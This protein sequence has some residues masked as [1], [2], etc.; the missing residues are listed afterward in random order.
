MQTFNFSNVNYDEATEFIKEN[1]YLI[2]DNLFTKE[3]CDNYVSRTINA[4]QTINPELNH[5]E[6]NKWTNI[7]LPPQT[8]TGMYQSLIC[9]INPVK[10]I[11]ENQN[12]KKIFSEIYSRIKTNYNVEDELVSS[13]DGINFKPNVRG[14]YTN[15]N[16]KDWAHLDQTKRNDIYKC[17]QGQVVFTNTS[18]SFVCSPKSHKLHDKILNICG[19]KEKDSSNWCKIPNEKYSKCKELVE[20]IGGHWQ[21]PIKVKA[22]TCILWFSTTIHSAKHSEKKETFTETDPY[23]GY[24]CV[25]YI[26]YRPKNEFTQKQIEKIQTNLENNRNMNHWNT[27]TFPIC[28]NSGYFP[29]TNYHENIQVLINNPKKMYELNI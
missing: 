18:A 21:I 1:G 17:L 5:R 16:S 27:R 10:E 3:Q 11:R 12:Y 6:N 19:V 20:S 4:F 15:N 22:G 23:L 9:N 29:K 25:Y 7:M 8:R 13:I 14:P 28:S 24:R 2:I 26:T